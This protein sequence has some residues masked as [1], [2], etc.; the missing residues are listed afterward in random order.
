MLLKLDI[1]L[2]TLT[3]PTLGTIT[4]EAQTLRNAYKIEAQST[5]I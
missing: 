3:L 2:C 5:L 4:Y 1:Q